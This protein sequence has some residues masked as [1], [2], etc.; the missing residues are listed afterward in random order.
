[1]RILW[2]SPSDMTTES[3]ITGLDSLG[4]HTAHVFRYDR[5]GFPVD[6]GM[7]DMADR[8]RPDVIL[9]IGQNNRPFLAAND[10]FKR[11]KKIA[12]MV[13]LAFDASDRTWTDIMRSYC[14]EDCFTLMVNIDG[15]DDWPKREQDFTALTP[16]NPEFYR[17]QIPLLE[18]PIKFA[19]AGGYSSQSR[20]EIVEYLAKHA[21]LVIPPRNE[22]YGSYQRYADFMCQTQIVLNVPWSGSDNASQVKGRVLEAGWAGCVLLD[23]ESTAAK[24][25]F[26]SGLDYVP[27]KTPSDAADAVT[28]LLSDQEW[29][30]KLAVHHQRIV[31]VAH[32]PAVFWRNVFQRISKWPIS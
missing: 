5:C 27:Y 24:D 21:G 30:Q 18:R 20:R 14:E 17:E 12:P 32:S 31:R 29:M 16:T 26:R 11:L 9:Y 25:W 2:L 15:C 1:M 19:F 13:M 10:T 23:H 8:M 6:R 4:E 3:V 22:L 28:Q 7:L